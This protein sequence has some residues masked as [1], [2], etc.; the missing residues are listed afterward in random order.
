MVGS[1]VLL[2]YISEGS[3]LISERLLLSLLNWGES[4]LCV[5][6]MTE[7]HN[8]RALGEGVILEGVALI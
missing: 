8:E 1:Q 5:K 6:K 7:S 4:I 2:C 3:S